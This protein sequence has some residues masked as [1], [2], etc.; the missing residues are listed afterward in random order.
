MLDQERQQFGKLVA[1]V[2]AYYGRDS[3]QFMLE[4]FWEALQ[5]FELHDVKR[6]FSVYAQDAGRGQFAPKVAD[7]VR[8][9]E[10]GSEDRAA[11]AWAKVLGAVR[12]IGPYAS[13][14]FDDPLIHAAL[15]ACGGFQRLCDSSSDDMPF[16]A[17]EFEARYRGYIAR[18]VTPPYPPR[19]I[20]ITEAY[21]RAHGFEADI[22]PPMLVGDRALALEVERRGGAELQEQ[23][24]P[25]LVVV[26]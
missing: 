26:N 5:R 6:A 7:I 13:I 25:A 3:S 14:V 22:E 10:G 4:V 24:R 23:K 11:L 20:G 19:V 8:I 16:R 17:K 2:M 1:D 18:R 9:V 15:D 12:R 21:N